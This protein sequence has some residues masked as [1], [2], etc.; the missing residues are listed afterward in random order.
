MRLRIALILALLLCFLPLP[1]LADG[2]VAI[3][4]PST[5]ESVK[6][7]VEVSGYIKASNTSGF[8]L[9]FADD[10]SDTPGWYLI[11]SGEKLAA[12]G[13]LGVWDTTQITDGNYQL[14][15]T[16]RLNDGSASTAI[17]RGLRVRNYTAVEAVTVN[18]QNNTPAPP[19]PTRIS[20]IPTNGQPGEAERNPA[21][22]STVRYQVHAVLA[23]LIGLAVGLWLTYTFRKQKPRL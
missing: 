20:L 8:D 7:R 2:D 1:V 10:Q 9:E 23:V 6:G 17:I 13:M 15:L 16:V 4:S 14:R 11:N 12:D 19:T 3:L 21:E 5:G 18:P 22:I